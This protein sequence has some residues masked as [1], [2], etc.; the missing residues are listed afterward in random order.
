M[1]RRSEVLGHRGIP[2]VILSRHPEH[3][4]RDTGRIEWW[5]GTLSQT[6]QRRRQP[7]CGVLLA[8]APIGGAQRTGVPFRPDERVGQPIVEKGGQAVSFERGGQGLVLGRPEGPSRGVESKAR[9]HDDEARYEIR[10]P[11]GEME[12]DAPPLRVADHRGGTGGGALDRSDQ[13]GQGGPE[14]YGSD[15]GRPVTRQVGCDHRMGEQRG[16]RGEHPAV[17]AETVEAED[18][19]SVAGARPDR[20]RSAGR[21]DVGQLHGDD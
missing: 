12:C 16:E 15:V 5:H 4:N 6:A 18:R 9:G 2:D 21:P 17:E 20:Q 11:G 7:G 1:A 10:A 19:G 14:R 13:R 8:D 3:G